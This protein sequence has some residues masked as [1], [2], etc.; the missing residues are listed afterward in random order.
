[1]ALPSPPSASTPP[2]GDVADDADLVR[3]QQQADELSLSDLPALSAFQRKMDQY[4]QLP[5]ERQGV[6][7]ARYQRSLR[8]KAALDDG[9]L[10][11]AMAQRA[12]RDIAE[13]ERA[14]EYLLMSNV[15]LVL[16]ICREQLRQR[17]SAE[18]ARSLLP[19][20]VS[21]ANVALTEAASDYDPNLTPRFSTYAARKIRDHV[22]S[23]LYQDEVLELPSSVRRVQAISAVIGHEF[24]ATHGRHPSIDELRQLVYERAMRWAHGRLTEQQRSLPPERQVELQQARL[25]KQGMLRAIAEL[26]TALSVGQDPQRLDAPLGDGSKAVVAD[27]VADT[28]SDPAYESAEMSTLRRALGEALSALDE[29]QREIVALRYGLVDNRQRTYAE[30]ARALE[31]RYGA[32][33]AERVRQIE[34]DVLASIRA[35]GDVSITL[36][37][38]LD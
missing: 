6:L 17:F 23:R 24:L 7:A 13:G 21:E 1:M 5:A 8:A 36:S 33:S 20:I 31:P 30:V 28:R 12:R 10:D 35:R 25:R 11:A 26:D 34:K 4:P 27:R 15:R 9:R 2:H 29:R 32:L 18:R 38:F 16:L 3:L 14:L 37:A 22:R 19:D